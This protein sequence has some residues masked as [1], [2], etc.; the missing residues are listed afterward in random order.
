MWNFWRR[1]HLNRAERIVDRQKYWKR[2]KSQ[3]IY[4]ETNWVLVKIT[5]QRLD[6]SWE[7]PKKQ[8]YLIVYSNMY[9]MRSLTIHVH[10]EDIPNSCLVDVV[11][12][13]FIVTSP[14]AASW[15]DRFSFR[16]N[17]TFVVDVWWFRR[18]FASIVFGWVFLVLDHCFFGTWVCWFEEVRISKGTLN[19]SNSTSIRR[20][21][22]SFEP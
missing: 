5:E 4:R 13:I 9:G 14:S 16:D 6:S 15:G 3:Q 1:V 8:V 12:N 21:R 20:I 18:S 11:H 10:P 17:H 19:I 2:V 22:A 7:K